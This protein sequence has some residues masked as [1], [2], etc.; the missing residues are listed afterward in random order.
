MKKISS[1]FLVLFALMALP[2]SGRA[3]VVENLFDF[4]NNAYEHEF[5]SG[6]SEAGNVAGDV[7]TEGDAW[8]TNVN[9]NTPTRLF[10]N[11]SKGNHLQVFKTGRMIFHAAEGKL[12]TKIDIR[13]NGGKATKLVPVSGGEMVGN[14]WQGVA[15]SIKLDASATDYI[16]SILVYTT[17]VFT[18]E[19]INYT[20][21]ASIAEFNAL[22]A[23]TY[24]KLAL[25]NARVNGYYDSYHTY[26]VEDETGATEFTLLPVSLKGGD[27]LNGFVYV[28]KD[29]DALNYDHKARQADDFSKA[30]FTAA[31]GT[32]A[33][34]AIDVK[35]AGAEANVGRL[36]TISNVDIKKVGRFYFA[37]ANKDDS[38][39]V[40][41]ELAVLPAGYE[42]PAKA[43]SLTGIVI[44][45]GARWEIMPVSAEAIEA[46]PTFDFTDENLRGYVGTAM[47][48]VQGYIY[49]ETYDAN[50]IKLQ[51]TGGSAPSRIYSDKNRGNNLVMYK[52]YSELKFTAPEG[53]AISKIEFTYAGTGSLNFTPSSGK[54]EGTVWTGN[55]QGVRFINNGTAYLSNA[56]VTLVDA[57]DETAAL[58]AIEYAEVSNIAAFNALEAGTYAKLTLTDAEVT[59]ISADGYSTAFIQDATGGTIVQYTS[60]NTQLKEK[61]KVNGTIYAVKR[62]A[63]G[64]PQVKEAEDTQNSQL[65]ATDLSDYTVIEGTIDQVN[66]PENLNR[67]VKITG[68][69]FEATSATAGTLTLGESTITVNNGAATANQQLHKLEF[70]K[71]D[72]IE[73]VT[74]ISILN[75]SSASKNQLLPISM[76][77]NSTVGVRAASANYSDDTVYGLQGVKRSQ[78]QKGLNIVNGKKVVLK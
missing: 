65:T 28:K 52:E 76:V 45:N 7:L 27:V 55:A 35:D 60:L 59:G 38:I 5:A 54:L 64:N 25:N 36:L 37:F 16:D 19:A 57:T 34:V 51:V 78:A 2:Q 6:L 44:F 70:A 42:F 18:P 8:I 17:S 15:T 13:C 3:Q 75:A 66:V 14:V 21:V 69:A 20:E 33:G 11:S 43:K 71:G 77:D 39:Q 40:K 47:T 67:V 9:G 53:K 73:N 29:Y 24:A 49:N 31:A 32:L 23:G 50:G 12:I 56:N 30:D 68:A 58:A 22:E 61:T 41:D 10:T 63:S 72:K 48:D 26:Y 74:I 46:A 4:K 1:L 62:V